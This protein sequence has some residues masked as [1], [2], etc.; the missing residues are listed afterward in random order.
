MH[1]TEKYLTLPLISYQSV[2]DSSA[3]INFGKDVHIDT[4][5]R[6]NY[7]KSKFWTFVEFSI[8]SKYCRFGQE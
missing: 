3:W 8:L 5:L 4:K 6:K 2:Q 7:E 1:E